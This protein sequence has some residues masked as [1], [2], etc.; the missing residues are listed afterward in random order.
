M[1]TYLSPI[2]RTQAN[3]A[4]GRTVSSLTSLSDWLPVALT[5]EQ[6]LTWRW[7]GAQ[8]LQQPFFADEF[9]SQPA[10]QRQIAHTS[11]QQT[12]DL[13][14]S[15]TILSPN[16]IIFHSSR[17]GSTLLMQLLA[18]LAQ[19]QQLAE[20]GIL[21]HALQALAQGADPGLLNLV[22]QALSV[23]RLPEQQHLILKPDCWHLFD[24]ARLQTA[25]PNTPKYFL[26]RE[27]SAVLASHQRQCG[28]QMV[29]GM[30]DGNRLGF[31]ASGRFE[32]WPAQFL[33]QLFARALHHA[34]GGE[35][36]LI[37]YSQLP[38]ILW[39]YL[40]PA[41]GIHPSARELQQMQ[42][43]CTR[44]AKHGQEWQ[45][46]PAAA[47]NCPPALQCAYAALETCR[48]SQTSQANQAERA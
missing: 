19:C 10:A 45:G 30:L 9:R 46:D 27:P 20:P 31:H 40:L 13:L 4:R 8:G 15:N 42:E 41:W 17:C 38:H 26:Y 16:A 28:P 44:H 25:L 7:L 37:N 6:G 34:Q 35:L 5:P 33:Q 1:P 22:L 29:P 39:E 3:L 14:Q 11:P 43:R 36:E 48:L 23:Q 47:L 2:A 24:F 21:E 32:D 12:R 18:N